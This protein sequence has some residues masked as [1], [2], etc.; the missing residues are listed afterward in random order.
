MVKAAGA[1]LRKIWRQIC[2]QIFREIRTLTLPVPACPQG[3]VSGAVP[4]VL[5][6][7]PDLHP[8][9]PEPCLAGA[10]ELQSLIRQILLR[11]SK[12]D[13]FGRGA[14]VIE[15]LGALVGDL[16]ASA[17][18]HHSE[19]NGLLRHSLEVG[20]KMVEEVDKQLAT[21]AEL[22][23]SADVSEV[24]PDAPQ[25]QYLCF[26][27]GVGHDLG[28]LFD[29]DLRAGD[30]RWSPLHE[31]H[32]EFL[33]RVKVEPVL[34]WDEDRVR[35]G[36]AQLS[37]WLMH[38]LLTPADVRFIGVERL[39]Q[40]A[41]GLTGAHAGEQPTPM[42]RLVRKLDQESV[43]QAAPEWLNKRPDSKVNQFVR[44]LRCLIS[45]GGLSV[46]TPGAPVYVTNDKAAIVVPRR[47]GAVRHYLKQEKLRLPNN[48][49][50]YDLLAQ[51]EVVQ[52]D[53][54]RQCVK[55]IRVPGKHGPVELS[56]VI[57]NQE[58]IIPQ[59]ILPTLPRVTFEIV[60]EEPKPV[61]VVANSAEGEPTPAAE[62][63]G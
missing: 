27:A 42:A 33:Q 38:H 7:P 45:E 51:A 31:T 53:G 2:R 30:Q 26:L 15:R 46:N 3:Q 5:K 50:L 63:L 61:V 54:D 35:G 59:Q 10:P 36:H 21:H 32:A 18:H 34:R 13:N 22:D 20:L 48:H 19:P 8:A 23:P 14:A 62:L 4:G 28:K 43:E 37:P 41:A 60:P 56:A 6:L 16:P 12:Y 55:K 11:L 57:F 39:P 29:M 52:A 49:C 24:S 40:L 58:T 17:N 47:V 44:G 9:K 1:V 25:W